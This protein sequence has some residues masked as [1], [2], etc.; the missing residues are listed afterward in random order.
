[1]VHQFECD[2]NKLVLQLP[3]KS[4]NVEFV[5]GV[6]V[7]DD[8]KVAEHIESLN[9][10]KF[11]QIRRVTGDIKQIK[12]KKKFKVTSGARGTNSGE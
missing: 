6:L 9:S 1:M 2:Y 5:G 8:D 4:G 7:T 11:G 10:F 3:D 12:D